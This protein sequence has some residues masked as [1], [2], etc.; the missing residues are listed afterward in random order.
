MTAIKTVS[1]GGKNSLQV[2]NIGLGTAPIGHTASVPDSD[3][4][5]TIHRA[6]ELGVRLFDSAPLYGMGEAE[7]RIGRA[8]QG[9]PR[10]SYVLSTKI[11]RVLNADRSAF[12]YDYSH[13]GVMRSIEGSLARLQTD[14]LDIVLVHDPD[15]DVVD[16]EQDALDG[17]FPTLQD[18]RDQ[19]VIKALGAGMNQWQM[20]QR[21]AEQ[22]DPDVFLLA[23]RYTLLEQTS[24]AFLQRC[25]EK[26]IGIF[27]GGVYNSGILATGPHETAQ[28]NYMNAPTEILE[29]ARKIKAI[30]DRY[31]VG[32]NVA[33]LH[34]SQAHPAVT[35]LVVGAVKPSEVEANIAALSA[36]VPAALWQEL[37]AENLIEVEAPLPA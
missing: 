15:A 18:L 32:L 9:I 26:G 11:G 3:A 2:T 24:L 17:A 25:K 1:L 5:A 36:D 23:G 20:E 4:D 7:I 37:R 14:R 34:F 8:L 21:F 33:A 22:A 30:T 19:G 10:D 31:N 27:L 29:K 28:Y 12:V 16:H 6:Y 35:S 13:D